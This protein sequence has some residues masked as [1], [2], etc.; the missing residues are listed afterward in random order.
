[1]ASKNISKN[2]VEKINSYRD[3]FAG[4][5][6][7]LSAKLDEFKANKEEFYRRWAQ[8]SDFNQ[9]EQLLK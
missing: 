1:M 4:E 7:S 3:Y 8:Y 9:V 2:A 6:T 5:M